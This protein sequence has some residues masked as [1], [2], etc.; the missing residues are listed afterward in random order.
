MTR[1]NDMKIT[2]G[3][4]AT[5][6]LAASLLLAGAVA[7]K[8]GSDDYGVAVESQGGSPSASM[9]PMQM[10]PSPGASPAA[11]AAT[12]SG[13]V[14]IKDFSF[15]PGSI[16]VAVGSTV[17][18]TNDDTTGHTVTADDGSFDSGTLAPGAT[19]SNTFSTAGTFAYHCNIHHSMTATITVG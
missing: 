19:F 3:T 18:W 7:A 10:S 5:A 9:A 17:T 16:S 1:G 12:A 8:S 6:V 2:F 15:Q 11:S 14:S 4:A 13:A